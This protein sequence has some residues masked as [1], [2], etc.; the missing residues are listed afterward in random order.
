MEDKN[1]EELILSSR[2][3]LFLANN[4]HSIY[5]YL[6]D[7]KKEGNNIDNNSSNDKATAD[8]VSLAE[9]VSQLL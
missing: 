9:N 7:R 2:K 8:K 1:A 4:L 6:K 3:H 5:N